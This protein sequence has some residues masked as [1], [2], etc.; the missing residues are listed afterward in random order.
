[1]I[2]KIA[3]A[4]LLVVALVILID[5]FYIIFFNGSNNKKNDTVIGFVMPGSSEDIGWNGMNYRGIV[6]ACNTFQVKLVVKENVSEEAG[7]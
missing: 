5:I 3:R 6:E 1:M 2:K 7:K 4:L